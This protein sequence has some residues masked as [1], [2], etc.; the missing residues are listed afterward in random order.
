[1]IDNGTKVYF[2]LSSYSERGYVSSGFYKMTYK[3]EE[4]DIHLIDTDE[5]FICVKE[6]FLTEEEA[7]HNLNRI[8][9][10]HQIN[11]TKIRLKSMKELVN[12]R[13]KE[14]AIYQRKLD[15]L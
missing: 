5:G 14:L 12:E 11:I 10:E 2:V 6:I 9:I 8:Y 7:E 15:E 4:K 1:M 13:E 3:E